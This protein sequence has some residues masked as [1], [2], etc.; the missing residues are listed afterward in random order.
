MPPT[1]S[2]REGEGFGGAPERLGVQREHSS[3][4][5][6]TRW[7]LSSATRHSTIS[8]WNRFAVSPLQPMTQA[9]PRGILIM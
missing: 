9:S 3:C 4:C 8:S 1:H 2:W 5:L 7:P 6:G